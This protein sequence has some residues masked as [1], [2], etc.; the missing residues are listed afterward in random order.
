MIGTH[1][2]PAPVTANGKQPVDPSTAEQED[3]ARKAASAARDAALCDAEAAVKE[4]ADTAVERDAAAKL[5]RAAH[6]RAAAAR[7]LAAATVPDPDSPSDAPGGDG[8]PSEVSD[9][10]RVATIDAVLLQET[11]AL[12]NLHA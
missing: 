4:A 9:P 10:D 12:L 1:V 3:E 7:K 5:A 11:A 2:P 6:V 8:A